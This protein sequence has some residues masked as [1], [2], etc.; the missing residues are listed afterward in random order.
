MNDQ[1]KVIA[2]VVLLGVAIVIGIAIAAG[3]GGGGNDG[4][5]G[6]GGSPT[7]D[8]ACT[9]ATSGAGLVAAGLTKGESAG[10]ILA[11]VGGTAAVGFGCKQAIKAM[12]NQPSEP[13]D[14]GIKATDGTTVQETTT[15]SE[16]AQ[17]PPQSKASNSC[18]DW[19]SLVLFR[20]CLDGAIGP[21]VA[22]Q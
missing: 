14:L 7:G 20:L 19:G 10:A 22:S 17:P 2:G 13:V 3:D 15:G 12:V 11:S 6:N 8:L 16:L 5:S 21:P 4:T 1:Q 18:F 9:L